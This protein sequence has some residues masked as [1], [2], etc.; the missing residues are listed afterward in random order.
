MRIDDLS[1]PALVVDADALDHN[2]ATMATAHPGTTLRP[3]V[4]AHKCTALARRQSTEHG[5][6][7]F[8]C[9]TIREVPRIAA[10]TPRPTRPTRVIS[11]RVCR[12]DVL[13]AGSDEVSQSLA[14]VVRRSPTSSAGAR[15]GPAEQALP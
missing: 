9:A 15:F 11:M 5:H 13:M 1:T 2:L 10:A 14:V 7:G 8:T 12:D 4:K 6:T 3:H